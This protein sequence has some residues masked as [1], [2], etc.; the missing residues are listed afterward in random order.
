MIEHPGGDM[1]RWNGEMTW[2]GSWRGRLFYSN[3]SS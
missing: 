3:T 1:A 2:P